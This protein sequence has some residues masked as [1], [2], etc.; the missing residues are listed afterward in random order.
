VKGHLHETGT[1]IVEAEQLSMRWAEAEYE[2]S[3]GWAAKHEMS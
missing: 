2:M 3:G 1:A